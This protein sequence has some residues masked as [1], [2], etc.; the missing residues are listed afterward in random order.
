M[1]G[2]RSKSLSKCPNLFQAATAEPGGALSLSLRQTHT[3]THT[4]TTFNPDTG[5]YPGI[6]PLLFTKR[7]FTRLGPKSLS[8]LLTT[9]GLPAG[10][11][12]PV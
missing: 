3:N 5:I 10:P 7:G 6:I 1:V 11:W 2:I 4:K 12:P 8:R 9:S